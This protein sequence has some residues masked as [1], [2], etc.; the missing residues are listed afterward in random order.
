ME[1]G[2]AGVLSL[3]RLTLQEPRIAARAVLALN[4]PPAA[5]WM[6]A[7]LTT[8]LAA[9]LMTLL[10]ALLPVE[11]EDMP[12][13]A[14]FFWVVLTGLG[15]LI[16][17]SLVYQVGRWFGGR[18]QFAD[19]LVLMAWLQFIQVGIAAAQMIALLLIP[20]LGGM[21]EIASLVITLW[22]LTGFI[23][24]LH[25]F[26]SAGRVFGGILLTF[27]V[28]VIVLTMLLILVTAGG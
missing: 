21:I 26:S 16:S 27:A 10:N 9:I 4:L 20:P 19:A 15:M 14:P 13:I 17:T 2:K 12:R 8:L 23:A 25:G 7:G 6:A 18:G 28:S 22:L 11:G 5:R 24:E 1:R 3:V